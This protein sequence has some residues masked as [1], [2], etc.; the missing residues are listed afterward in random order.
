MT[1]D[2]AGRRAGAALRDRFDRLPAP[3]LAGTEPRHPR[4]GRTAVLAGVAAVLVVALVV[5]LVGPWRADEQVPAGPGG[6]WTRVSQRT[7]FGRDSFPTVITTWRGKLL[8]LGNARAA[9]AF[10]GPDAAAWTSDDGI[11]WERLRVTAPPSRFNGFTSAAT[12]GRVI[13]AMASVEDNV[14]FWRSTDGA[15]WRSVGMGVPTG[16]TTM[17]TVSR[18]PGG[19]VATSQSP[20]GFTIALASRDG[21]RW[22]GTAG[23]R[24]L[25]FRTGLFPGAPL[26]PGFITFWGSVPGTEQPLVYRSR[27][28]IRWNRI[29]DAET[30]DRLGVLAS[31][32]RRTRVLGIQFEPEGTFGGRLWSTTDGARWT[33][34]PSF[35]DQMPTGSPDHLVQARRWWVLG[36][37]RGTADGRRRASMWTSPDLQHWY[38]MPTRLRGAKTQGVGMVLVAHDGR[39]IGKAGHS[40]WIWTPP[41]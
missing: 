15:H 25:E 37:N 3:P 21:T 5:A 28:R 17:Y 26:R 31:D 23:T 33:E 19:F 24:D 40:L 8:A 2:D 18:R 10:A 29:A 11:H 30:P 16:P 35:H 39:V 12:R 20:N 22:N 38:E 1:V 13:V 4:S 27:D 34:I 6:T 32:D 7:A 14:D 41:E 9:Q 36:G